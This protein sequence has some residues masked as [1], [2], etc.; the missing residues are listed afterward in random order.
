ME[1]RRQLGLTFILGPVQSDQYRDPQRRAF[2]RLWKD[3][4]VPQTACQNSIVSQDP[5]DDFVWFVCRVEVCKGPPLR[6]LSKSSIQSDHLF[7]FCETLWGRMIRVIRNASKQR[8]RCYHEGILLLRLYPLLYC[9]WTF[10]PIEQ[11]RTHNGFEYWLILLTR[12]SL[13]ALQITRV[14]LWRMAYVAP[15]HR[16]G[17][18]TAC[19][20]LYVHLTL[21]NTNVL[22]LWPRDVASLPAILCNERPLINICQG[23]SGRMMGSDKHCILN[24]FV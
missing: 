8:G 9:F 20:D 12:H 17:L 16:W 10:C 2:T 23:S 21:M 5:P 7:S 19:T 6:H 15:G 18:L 14:S 11:Y 4:S 22:C 1:P 13:P 3:A 24:I